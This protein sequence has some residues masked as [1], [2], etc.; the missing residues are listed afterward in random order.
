MAQR[1]PLNDEQ[2]RLLR[3]IAR[4]PLASA[5]NLAPVM[6]I[7]ED[8]VR[9]MLATLRVGGWADSVMWGMTERR[10]H[11][12]F[13]TRQAVDAL[14]TSGH[15]HPSPKEEARA[16]GLAQFH[17]EGELPADYRERFALNH[18]HAVHLESQEE[19]PFSGGDPIGEQED[20]GD[21]VHEHPPWTATSRGVETSLRRLAML[22]PVYALAPD[23]LRSGRVVRPPGETAAS[24]D[25]RM[26]DF[27]LLRHGSPGRAWLP[28]PAGGPR[29]TC[30]A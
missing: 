19:S 13:L 6:D 20:S 1:G 23:L 15:Q 24:R 11:R 17:P 8:R 9:R 12:W 30:P 27:R 7:G 26:T 18:D 21:P 5:A 28:S 14:Y 29:S 4:M 3:I 10:Q 25:A 16:Q 22:E 2:R